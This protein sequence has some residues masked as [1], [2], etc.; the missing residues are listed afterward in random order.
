MYQTKLNVILTST[1]RKNRFGG[2]TFYSYVASPIAFKWLDR[3]NFSLL[4]NKVFP[5]FFQMQSISPVIL[6]FT[7]PI[8]LAGG[9]LAALATASVAGLTNLCWLL[10]K[11]RRIKEERK[12]LQT[13]LTGEELE[14]FDGPLR[15]QFG[16]FHG[17][18]LLFNL[19]NACGMFVYGIYLCKGLLRYVPK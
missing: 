1:N 12:S 5:I 17:L 10:P 7:A 16:K 3:E 19:T 8:S 6:G 9:P 11:T 18:S 4:Q 15:K 14:T 2:T 13:R